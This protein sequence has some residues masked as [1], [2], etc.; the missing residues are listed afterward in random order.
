MRNKG[1][2]DLGKLGANVRHPENE[3]SIINRE[4]CQVRLL[5][6]SY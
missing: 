4:Y 3:V 1:N 5:I 6:R 2:K